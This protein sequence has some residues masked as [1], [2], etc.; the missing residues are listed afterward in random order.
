MHTNKPVFG[1]RRGPKEPSTNFSVSLPESDTLTT[2]LMSDDP[3]LLG[4]DWA[5][6]R[7]DAAEKITQS[8]HFQSHT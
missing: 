7:S 8:A 2:L 5:N 6:I 4:I 1:K 3:S